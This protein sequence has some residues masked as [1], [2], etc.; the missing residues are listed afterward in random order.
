M[1]F[2]NITLDVGAAMNAFKFV[3]S[4]PK[5]FE[6]VVIHLGDF[7][8]IK[9][10]F[11]IIGMLVSSSGF[12]DVVFQSNVC[13]SGSLNGVINGSLYNEAWNVH[14]I[15]SEAMERTM[16][17]RYLVEFQ[18][19]LP[20]ALESIAADPETYDDCLLVFCSD[21]IREYEKFRVKVSCGEFGKTA[22]F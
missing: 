3:W 15:C 9:E 4:S 2:V 20:L 12:E 13:S 11:Q 7:H 21:I 6:N 17:K 18:P 10:N 22:Q 14:G 16:L 5:R 1:P 19:D 8:F